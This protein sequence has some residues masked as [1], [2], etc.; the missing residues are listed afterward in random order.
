MASCLQALHGYLAVGQRALH[1][2]QLFRK[3][4]LPCGG[5]ACSLCGDCGCLAHVDVA[6]GELEC[7]GRS[8]SGRIFHLQGLCRLL[9]HVLHHG[10]NEHIDISVI[11]VARERRNIK[12]LAAGLSHELACAVCCLGV[13]VEVVEVGVIA[14]VPS[15]ADVALL[16][17]EHARCREVAHCHCGRSVG[18]GKHCE[19]AERQHIVCHLCLRLHVEGNHVDCLS[20]ELGQVVFCY[21][22]A[23]LVCHGRIGERHHLSLYLTLRGEPYLHRAGSAC[24]VYQTECSAGGDRYHGLVETHQMVACRELA[25]YLQRTSEVVGIVPVDRHVQTFLVLNPVTP[26]RHDALHAAVIPVLSVLFLTLHK[27]VLAETDTEGCLERHET[28]DRTL[29]HTS[30]KTGPAE[31]VGIGR[32]AILVH[33]HVSFLIESPSL[34]RISILPAFVLRAEK[35]LYVVLPYALLRTEQGE[36]T[37]VTVDR[38]SPVEIIGITHMSASY[39]LHTAVYL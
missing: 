27:A 2:F 26:C 38:H 23:V 19:L 21:C 15:H 32:V 22:P 13:D 14:V 1:K 39:H 28:D 11:G 3:S 7:H 31:I 24:L 16:L 35:V 36:G 9:P 33:P 5:L 6:L 17:T 30:G 20:V 37:A 25:I 10:H 18:C 4:P 34:C 29:Q 12:S 8:R